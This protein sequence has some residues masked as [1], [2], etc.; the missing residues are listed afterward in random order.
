MKTFYSNAGT[1]RDYFYTQFIAFV[2]RMKETNGFLWLLVLL[3]FC[4]MAPSA[5]VIDIF[6]PF[7]RQPYWILCLLLWLQSRLVQR[8]VVPFVKTN[9]L[10]RLFSFQDFFFF[11][12]CSLCYWNYFLV[13]FFSIFCYRDW[14][15]VSLGGCCHF[16]IV[17]FFLISTFFSFEIK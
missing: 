12:F 16:F 5:Y 9:N 2:C 6:P 10:Q 1:I 8:M 15:V 4:N 17:V 13:T 11:F 3:K 7:W 14:N